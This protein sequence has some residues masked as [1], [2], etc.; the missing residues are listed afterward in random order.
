[1]GRAV[2]RTDP[3]SELATVMHSAPE[4][5]MML[6]VMVVMISDD[7]DDSDD[8]DDSYDSY[9]SDDSDDH[10]TCVIT[11]ACLGSGT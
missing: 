2:C 7:G 10:H 6:I 1:M 3:S 8:S 9:D 11:I 4:L 5:T